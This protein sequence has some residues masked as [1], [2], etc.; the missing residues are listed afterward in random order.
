LG[1]IRT[2]SRLDFLFFYSSTKVK[3]ALRLEQSPVL[4]LSFKYLY[5][6]F[7]KMLIKCSIFTDDIELK[8]YQDKCI[9]SILIQFIN[10][11]CS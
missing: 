5:L 9:S 11:R 3:S 1:R 7:T 4:Y 10:Q 6:F 8:I 2:Q